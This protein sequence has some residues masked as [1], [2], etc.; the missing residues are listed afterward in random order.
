LEYSSLSKR[1]CVLEYIENNWIIKDGYNG[2]NSTNGTWLWLNSKYEL[3]E[4][5][6]VRVGS[7]VF[8]ISIV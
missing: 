3:N 6:L 7:N 2:K 8:K 5:T 1:H 4:D